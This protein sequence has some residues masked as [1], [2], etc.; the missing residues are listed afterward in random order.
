MGK[1]PS[2]GRYARERLSGSA[3]ALFQRFGYTHVSIRDI[4]SFVNMPKGA[5]YNHFSSKEALASFI[6]SHH[7]NALLESLGRGGNEPVRARLRQHFESIAPPAQDLK[8]SPLQLISTLAAEAPALPPAVA[9]QIAKGI[10]LW[11]NRV[12]A[13]IS[14]AQVRG[15]I[16]AEE[17]SELLASLLIN[18]WQGAM[19]RD[20]CDPSAR[21][22][23]L[24]L[25]L[26]RILGL[27]QTNDG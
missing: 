27:S 11:S 3:D 12:A 21:H 25:V 22:D 20:K 18:C 8:T 14:L 9:H 10:E 2:S 13:L 1:F 5:F 15:Q 23:C 16:D 7:F 6:L 17:N 26:D 4:T 19:I 24:R